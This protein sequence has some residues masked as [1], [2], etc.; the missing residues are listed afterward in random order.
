MRKQH[1]TKS[2]TTETVIRPWIQSITR[3]RTSQITRFQHRRKIMFRRKWAHASQSSPRRDPA[4]PFWMANH[5][6][7]QI[8]SKIYSNQ[9]QT[10]LATMH[11]NLTDQRMATFSNQPRRV[12]MLR[13]KSFSEVTQCHMRSNRATI[14]RL[15]IEE[16]TCSVLCMAVRACPTR[17][18]A[19]MITQS[20]SQATRK[21]DV[22]SST[23]HKPSS[24]A[25]SR[26]ERQPLAYSGP[27]E[28]VHR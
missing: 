7:K 20:W 18:S 13:L 27:T 23:S 17:S 12:P 9:L 19:V 28:K 3:S 24:R 2:L 11:F 14:S 8:R 1:P 25:H 6:V 21:T 10:Y 16:P 4:R 22:A 5:H 15:R 26:C